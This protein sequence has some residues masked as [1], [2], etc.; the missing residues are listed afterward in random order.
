MSSSH[1]I[2]AQD[3]KEEDNAKKIITHGVRSEKETTQEAEATKA[4]EEKEKRAFNQGSA[5]DSHSIMAQES[6]ERDTTKKIVTHGVWS[7]KEIS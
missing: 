7:D 2:A 4:E 6:K 3:G 5:D 1:S